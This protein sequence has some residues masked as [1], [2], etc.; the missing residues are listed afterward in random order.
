[1]MGAVLEYGQASGVIQWAGSLG[2]QDANFGIQAS[3]TTNIFNPIICSQESHTTLNPYHAI[4]L[5]F[6]STISKYPDMLSVL[7]RSIPWSQ[8]AEFF[9]HRMEWVRQCVF[10]RGYWKND[11]VK[12]KEIK[13]LDASEGRK[14]TDG[15]IEDD[16]AVVK[17]LKVQ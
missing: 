11:K 1:M 4:V 10:E 7:E 6:L 12:S 2:Q 15:I 17:L 3:D 13:L 8:L 16:P 5:T 9:I 14:V